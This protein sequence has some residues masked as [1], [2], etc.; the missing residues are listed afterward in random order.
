M[1]PKL[2]ARTNGDGSI[3]NGLRTFAEELKAQREAARLTQ[4]ELARLMGY[5]TSVIAKLETCRTIPSPQ[6]VERAD[7]ALKTPGT[8]ARLRRAAVNGAFEAW[9]RALLDLESR[10]AVLRWW[11]PLLVPGLLQTE[12]YARAMI[13]AGWPGGDDAETDQLVAARLTRQEIWQ[14]EMPPPPMLF[15]VIGEAVMRQQ[16]GERA[17][18]REQLSRL[19]EATDHPRITVQV[20]P[21]TTGA[22]PGMLGPFLIASFAEGPDAVYLDNALNGQVSERR[23]DVSRVSLLYDTLRSEALSPRAS[24]EMIARAVDEWT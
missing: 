21:F 18:M 16:V 22:H 23:L 7:A 20:M 24:R 3:H 15:A 10:A 13:R 6:H 19:A 11:E 9:V 4:E 12:G 1:A 17:V 5:S 2:G 8:F 14:R